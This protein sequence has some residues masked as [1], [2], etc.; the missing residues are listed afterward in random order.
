MSTKNMNVEKI[1]ELFS[2]DLIV[3]NMGLEVFADTLKKEG[4][5]VLP[6]DWRPPAGGNEKLSS[7]LKRLGR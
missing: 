1:T 5:R 3:V 6:M 4:G 7:L 2:R